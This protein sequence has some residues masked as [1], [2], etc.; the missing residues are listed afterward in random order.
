M[1]WNFPPR[2]VPEKGSCMNRSLEIK[3]KQP[4][5]TMA[6]AKDGIEL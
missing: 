2:G 6:W 3:V 4:L 5:S 1:S